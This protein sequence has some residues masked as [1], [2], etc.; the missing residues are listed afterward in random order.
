MRK[1]IFAIAIIIVFYSTLTYMLNKN[2]AQQETPAYA[3]WGILVIKETKL[4]YPKAK[5]IDYLHVGSESKAD[6]TI[7]K[8]KLWVK[9]ANKEFGVFVKI[10]FIT[11]TEEVIT[12][13][14]QETSR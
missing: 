13:E 10:T 7:E 5:I 4:K 2:H 14:F 11:E 12:I 1:T 3:K 9:D 6:Q 8:F